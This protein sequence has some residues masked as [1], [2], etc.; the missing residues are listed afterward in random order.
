MNP[1]AT[2]CVGSILLGLF[3]SDPLSAFDGDDFVAA[4]HNPKH[5]DEPAA[6][7][8]V[9][10]TEQRT[11]LWNPQE[12]KLPVSPETAI[13]LVFSSALVRAK[14]EDWII[15]KFQLQAMHPMLYSQ[16][17]IATSRPSNDPTMIASYS[18]DLQRL[19]DGKSFPF[20]VLMNGTVYPPGFEK[21]PSPPQAR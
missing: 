13:K 15:R 8:R 3:V 17:D 7:L 21:Q 5:P 6:V 20:M 12:G 11:S 2:V 9:P 18:I 1:I 4:H 10:K 19:S 16:L 14:P